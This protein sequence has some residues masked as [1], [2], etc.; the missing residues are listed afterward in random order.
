MILSAALAGMKEKLSPGGAIT[1]DDHAINHEPLP[2]NWIMHCS[3]LPAPA[4]P[5]RRWGR[6]IA[7]STPPASSRSFPNFPCASPMWNMTHYIR[8]V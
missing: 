8:T 7:A 4:L 1:G 6:N 5:M 2:T 3:A